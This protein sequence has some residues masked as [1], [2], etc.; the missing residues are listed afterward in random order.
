MTFRSVVALAFMALCLPATL[1]A[2]PAETPP[3]PTARDFAREPEI[4][5]LSISPSGKTLVGIVSPDAD[6]PRA[7]LRPRIGG[8]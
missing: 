6:T 3:G 4:H 8:L 1:R 5:G 7:F 2:A